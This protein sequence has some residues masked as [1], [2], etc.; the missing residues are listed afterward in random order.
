MKVVDNPL[1]RVDATPDAVGAHVN[2]ALPSNLTLD[3][4]TFAER[5][6]AVMG[7]G[8]RPLNV[9]VFNRRTILEERRR[10]RKEKFERR[11]AERQ[12]AAAQ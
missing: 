9:P 3:P 8:S 1:P 6:V 4:K 11:R 7:T 12:S 2:S 5:P 10:K